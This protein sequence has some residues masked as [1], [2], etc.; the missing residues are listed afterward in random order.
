MLPP[1]LP[2]LSLVI[3]LA[4]G[5]T[6][7]AATEPAAAQTAPAETPVEISLPA[8]AL[9]SA[10]NELARQA[11]LQLLVH[12]DLVAA[13][14]APALSGKFTARQ[15][16]TQLLAGSGLEAHL[17]GN[18]AIIKAAPSGAG[19]T[20]LPAVAVTGDF[21]ETASGHVEGYVA[22][23]SATGTKTDTPIVE[24]PQSISVI[25]ADRMEALGATR[26][27]DALTY[28]PGVKAFDS[29]DTR[30]DWLSIRGFDA[31]SPGFYLDGMQLRNNAGYSVWRTETYGAE[32][33][34]VLRGPA[35]VLYGQNSPGGMVNIVSKRP[36]EEPLHEL[37]AQIGNHSR[38][39]IAGDFSGPVDEDGKVLYR[40]TALGL[41]SN[42][43][44]DH[45]KDDR[46]Y[47]APAI[48]LK[49]S[50]D[51]TL[52]L[53]SHYFRIDAGNSYGFLPP[54]ATL[55]SNP[56]GRIPT[57]T[58]VGEPDFDRFNQTQWS[59]GYLFEHRLNDALTVRQNARFSKIETDYRQVYQGGFITTNP[60]NPKDPAN[61]REVE[62]YVFGSPE[63]G[64]V[65]TIDNQVQ[66]KLG[67]A[68]WQHTLLLG[69]DY[70]HGDYKQR[71]YFGAAPSL[72]IYAPVYGQAITIPDAYIDAH[73]R[74]A[75]TGFYLQ[76]Q[77]KWRENWVATL[78]GRYDTAK[79]KSHS[80][81]D[82]SNVNQTDNKF[83]GRAGLVY[84][85]PN[86]LAPY[87]S[88]ADSFSP[89]TT[90]DP[91]TSRPFK[92]ETG[93]Q[94]EIGLR[95]QPP[96]TRDMYSAA[97][98]DLRR[99]N[100]ITFGQ[101]FVPMQ[102][103]EVRVRGVE[104]EANFRPLPN[105]NTILA[106]TWTPE[107]KVTASS[108]PDQI[109]KQLVA[110]PRNQISFWT[111][112]RFSNGLK[113][114]AGVR[115]VGSTHG[116]NETA[117]AKIPSYTLFDAMLSYGYQ[118][119]TLALNVRNLTDRTYIGRNC[120]AYSCGYGERRTVIMTAAYRW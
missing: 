87:V 40:L 61:Y 80:Y 104:L 96:G 100:V 17:D 73:T 88:Y 15:A 30:Y 18:I 58:F 54:D 44:V 1:S 107:A 99:K 13:K 24:T 67:S 36:T 89:T 20:T 105:I 55:L 6:A 90:I 7:L 45:V 70:Q 26:V 113:A 118:H 11:H 114:G 59:V 50:S 34:E 39:Q 43:Q 92:P 94:Y 2:P 93:A 9:G 109:G 78:G 110:T 23:L 21:Q 69:L 83:S 3:A 101:G 97:I 47:I 49:P 71:S 68:D 22:R 48:T 42:T 57:S 108:D 38:R 27:T 74:L 4:L 77:I 84:L 86:G 112:Y 60:N 53:L 103:G 75:Q 82:G 95:Y 81:L 116:A 10:L 35:S 98:F 64:R 51:T 5:T 46:Y 115:F 119:W 29:F 63:N 72:D 16:L 12:P 117:P 32:R 41:D 33:I 8:Q 31:Y 28:T 19:A 79:V 25:T 56:N 91:S 62:R 66:A 52:T 111:D 102:T 106:Y 76:D 65:F 85:A 14:T 120:D 37:Q